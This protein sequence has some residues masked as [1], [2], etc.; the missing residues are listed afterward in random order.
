MT[1]TP[2]ATFSW[3]IGTVTGTVTGQVAGSGT[4]IAQTLMGSGSVT[5]VVTPTLNG[6]PGTPVNIVQTVNPT[7][8]V[9][10]VT[11]AAI[12]NGA[13]TNIALASTPSGASFSWTIGTVTGAVTGQAA[14]SGSTIAQTLT[15]NG[16]VT[17]IVT[18]TLNGC[19]GTP[20]NIVQAVNATTTTTA[21]T[22]QTVCP[23]TSPTF[24]TTASGT[25]P[26]LFVW[27]KGTTTIST[28]ISTM[29]NTSTLTMSN[30]QSA[31]ADSYSVE[32]TGACGTATQSATLNVKPI[33]T[34][35]INDV[36]LSEGTSSTTAFTFTVSLSAPNTCD[37]VTVNYAT[38]NG[39]AT[40]ADSDYIATSGTLTFAVNETSKTVTVNVNGDNKVEA[41]ETFF[42]NLTT[43]TNATILDAQGQGTI[44]NVDAATIAITDVTK[45]EGTGGTTNYAFS[46]SLS[47]PSDQ[48][49]VVNFA[50]ADGTA[51]LVDTDYVAQ[52]GTVTFPANSTASQTITIVVAADSN[53]E[54]NETFFVNLT[55]NSFPYPSIT[56]SDMQGQGTITNDDVP[57]FTSSLTDPFVCNGIGS[58]ILVTAQ[59]TNPNNTAQP[60]TFNVTL[61]SMLTLVPNTCTSTIGTCSPTPNTQVAWSGTI[62]AGQT[63]T[64]TYQAQIADGTPEGST[65]TINSDGSVGG[66]ATST[67]AS[68]TVTCPGLTHAPED[69][70]LSDQKA[71]SLVV[72]P[73]YTSKS[74]SGSDTKLHLSNTGETSAFVHLFFIDGATCN[75]AD[76]SVCLTP[77]A[78]INFLASEMDPDTTGWLIALVVDAQGNPIQNNGLLGNAFVNDGN[79]VGNYGAES[80]WAYSNNLATINGDKATLRFNGTSYDAMPN[81]FAVEIQSPRDVIG[82]KI[83]TVGMNGDITRNTLSGAAQLGIGV[84]YNGNEKPFG[85]FSGFLNGICQAS[86]TITGVSPR[87]PFTMA[88][89]IPSGQVGTIKLNIGGGVGLLLTPQNS[90]KWSGIRGLHK[91]GTT[92]TTITIPVLPPKC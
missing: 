75:Q 83:V 8:V 6:C 31:D 67:S 81:Q 11:P 18:P 26:F 85:S 30:V 79:Y 23:G 64:I 65:I 38:A 54:A 77:N 2:G 56:F 35:S 51:T 13:T 62:P 47:A 40:T 17:Y 84:A 39:T 5:Y 70:K 34:I 76:Y 16:S 1:G 90:K 73:Y 44:S 72:F 86:A 27:K 25:G 59:L 68:G 4:S 15:G 87:V 55:K 42:V 92:F 48:P 69:V 36:S 7:P 43:P 53:I 12:C 52:S 33:P 89:I 37:T 71:G 19:P 61:P 32:V 14:G 50:T 49:V 78:S 41:D 28:G 63:V 9:N 20:V 57:P 45:N 74:G 88:G 29:G 10:P 91:T 3:T 46:V 58:S 24:M 80:F 22:S 82:Q 21:L 60:A 66:V